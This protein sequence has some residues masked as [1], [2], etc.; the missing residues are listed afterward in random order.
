MTEVRVDTGSKATAVIGIGMNLAFDFAQY[1]DLHRKATSLN[2]GTG[3]NVGMEAAANSILY[4]FDKA[5]HE[6]LNNPDNPRP[7]LN[8]VDTIG[9]RITITDGPEEYSGIAKGISEGGELIVL[10][11]DGREIH[12]GSGEITSISD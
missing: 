8:V 1:A 11:D 6:S 9:E 3:T 5:Y 12:V 4:H 7:W 10:R 2:S